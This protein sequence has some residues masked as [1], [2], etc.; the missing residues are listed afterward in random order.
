MAVF[1]FY[2][3]HYGAYVGYQAATRDTLRISHL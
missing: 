3:P 2:A 1:R